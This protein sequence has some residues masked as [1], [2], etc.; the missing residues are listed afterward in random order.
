MSVIIM[1]RISDSNS[2]LHPTLQE[3]SD[4][5]LNI[6]GVMN[7]RADTPYDVVVNAENMNGNG[8]NS[9]TATYRTPGTYLRVCYNLKPLPF[10]LGIVNLSSPFYA[11]LV[12]P[13]FGCS[14]SLSLSL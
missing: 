8:S 12:H 5:T 4:T 1:C 3:S 7:L 2:E 14:L 11:I 9:N 13:I 6:D 10:H